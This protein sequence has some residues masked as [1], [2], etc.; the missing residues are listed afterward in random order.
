[1][2][3]KKLISIIARN[4]NLNLHRWANHSDP[5]C[6]QRMDKCM[7]LQWEDYNSTSMKLDNIK[8]ENAK[9]KL[10]KSKK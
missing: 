9:N 1:M 4:N 3:F 5:H 6:I 2:I 8:V 10:N 7:A